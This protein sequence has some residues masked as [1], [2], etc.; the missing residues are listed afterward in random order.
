MSNGNLLGERGGL[1]D[2][3]SL[4]PVPLRR[5][6]ICPCGY[7]VLK[8]EIKVG[9]VYALDMKSIRKGLTYICGRCKV[10][11]ENLLAINAADRR[12]IGVVMA[13]LPYDLFAEG[14]KA[15]ASLPR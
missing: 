11:Q 10:R 3:A 7:S 14:F 9:T 12:G 8:D 13:P 5:V 6:S 15:H 4:T 2:P 1:V